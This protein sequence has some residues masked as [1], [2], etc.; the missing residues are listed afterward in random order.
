MIQICFII[1]HN[2]LKSINTSNTCSSA[3]QQKYMA[4]QGENVGTHHSLATINLHD[5]D[6]TASSK[7]NSDTVGMHVS[8]Q[9]A[10]RMQ[11]ELVATCRE[12]NVIS[13]IHLLQQAIIQQK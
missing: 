8:R 6:A 11:P 2:R 13:K 9:I 7:N 5:I 12:G 3:G 1:P 4:Y 10:Y